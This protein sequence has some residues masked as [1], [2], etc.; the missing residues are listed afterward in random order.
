MSGGCAIL[1][2]SDVGFAK[3]HCHPAAGYMRNGAR[4]DGPGQIAA[5]RDSAL[6]SRR[7]YTPGMATPVNVSVSR[8][9]IFLI[10]AIV[11]AVIGAFLEFARI[12]VQANVILGLVFLS[13]AFGWAAFL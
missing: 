1:S 4:I 10:L 9:L 3:T 2:G 7:A 6:R 5:D 11:A 13:L 8:H 12:D